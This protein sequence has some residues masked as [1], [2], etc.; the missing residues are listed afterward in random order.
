MILVIKKYEVIVAFAII[1]VILGFS[2]FNLNPPT[3]LAITAL[4]QKDAAAYS[5]SGKAA[6]TTLSYN[7]NLK[8]KKI[9][10]LTFDDGPH[11]VYTEHLLDALKKFNVPA[12]F[13]VVGKQAEKY[14]EILRHISE[15][16]FALGG[17]TYSHTHLTMFTED[18][19]DNLLLDELEKTR[20]IIKIHTGIDTYLFR[21]P[22]GR[23]DE[24]V[25]NISSRNGYHMV[26]WDVLPRDHIDGLSP[27]EISDR[28]ISGILSQGGGIVLL[29]SGRPSTIDALEK[30]ITRLRSQ[31]YEFVSLN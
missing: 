12:T 3:G 23:Y 13:F 14:P 4:P 30:I 5:L 25:V 27:D 22:G 28:V 21:P 31:G 19:K 9:V 1:L 8:G 15:K 11:P 7:T 18:K 26:L 2:T 20:H 24:K 16:G 29:H 17:H 10:A 6:D